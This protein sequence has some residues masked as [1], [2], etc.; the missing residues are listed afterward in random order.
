MNR[1]MQIVPVLFAVIASAAIAA[2]EAAPSLERGR[3]LFGSPA[4]GTSTRS[5]AAC[6]PA[7]KGLE[8]AASLADKELE[9]ITNKCIEKALKGKPLAVGTPDLASLVQYLKSLGDPKAK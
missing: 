7:G 5:C 8:D 2:A 3:Q 1:F 6:H 4:L 9:A